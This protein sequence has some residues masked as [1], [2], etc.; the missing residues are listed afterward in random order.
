MRNTTPSTSLP[1]RP[2]QRVALLDVLRGFALFGVLQSIAQ[3]NAN[4]LIYQV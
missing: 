4:D 1:V 2:S 3:F